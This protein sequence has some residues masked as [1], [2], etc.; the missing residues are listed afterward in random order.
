LLK[1]NK[2]AG[3]V[4]KIKDKDIDVSI[5]GEVVEDSKYIVIVRRNGSVESL[6]RPVSDELWIALEKEFP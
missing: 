5:V 6:V 3:I 1:K 4:N 2:A